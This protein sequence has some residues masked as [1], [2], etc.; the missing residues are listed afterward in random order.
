MRIRQLE[1]KPI[2]DKFFEW[3]DRFPFFGENAIAKAAE[4][5][6]SRA[7]ELKVFLHNGLVA[8]DNNP[9]EN[10]I[11]PNVIGRKIGFFL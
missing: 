11:R 4:Y 5:T 1:S 8:I 10:A 6:L 7:N 2:V 3:I 9:A